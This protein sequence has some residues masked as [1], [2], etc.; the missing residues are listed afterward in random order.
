VILTYSPTLHAAQTAGFDQ[1]LAK[2]TR[3]LAELAATLARGNTRR[4]PAAVQT[5]IGA[6]TRPRW[7]ARVLTTDLTGEHSQPT[8]A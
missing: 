6:I 7:V 2:A 1:T 8:C 4:P 5:A 3:A